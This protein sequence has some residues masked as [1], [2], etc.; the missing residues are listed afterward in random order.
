[1]CTLVKNIRIFVDISCDGCIHLILDETIPP[2]FKNSLSKLTE[3]PL[4][5]IMP[6]LVDVNVTKRWL[7]RF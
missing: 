2:F 7:P 5:L 4:S 6:S 1:M 3:K